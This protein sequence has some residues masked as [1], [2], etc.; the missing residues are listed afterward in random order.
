MTHSFPLRGLLVVMALFGILG[1]GSGGGGGETP[2]E[3]ADE[4]TTAEAGSIGNATLDIAMDALTGV[5][6]G[7]GGVLTL[8]G[9]LG[10]LAT[11]SPDISV[12]G[13]D[14]C[15]ST[16]L[17]TCESPSSTSDISIAGESGS[18]AGPIAVCDSDRIVTLT[19]ADFISGGVTLNGTITI[20][21]SGFASCEITSAISASLTSTVYE[22]SCDVSLAYSISVADGTLTMTGCMNA[23]ETG[24]S[25]STS[26]PFAS[27]CEVASECPGADDVAAFAS[28]FGSSECTYTGGDP[29]G[30]S[31]FSYEVI[32]AAATGQGWNDNMLGCVFNAACLAGERDCMT[33]ATFLEVAGGC[34]IDMGGGGGGGLV[35]VTQDACLSGGY[36]ANCPDLPND[37]EVY[38]VADLSSGATIFKLYVD[39]T[40]TNENVPG[41]AYSLWAVMQDQVC[42][43][44]DC[45]PSNIDMAPCD[46]GSVCYVD[47]T[48][49]NLGYILNYNQN[50]VDNSARLA[51]FN[52]GGCVS[53]W[54]E[55]DTHLNDVFNLASNSIET[56]IH[57]AMG[58]CP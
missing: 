37:G 49:A 30:S 19:C 47:V 29:D 55:W 34:G 42:G 8:S 40:A 43:S 27:G 20:S 28:V 4:I 6:S 51:T 16:T 58:S 52:A 53:I 54:W 56:R 9:A 13:A 45:L 31:T 10:A 17:S 22:T 11:P 18:C 24:F 26:V 1:C 57:N 35:N 2:S 32:V 50:G 14:E 7:G 33:W 46:E 15:A 5:L 48:G 36:G 41:L 39:Y 44:G 23:C 25:M 38:T 21:V 12:A 3:T